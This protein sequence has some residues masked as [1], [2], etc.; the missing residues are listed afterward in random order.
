MS[1]LFCAVKASGKANENLCG[2]KGTTFFA[3]VQIKVQFF[4][5]K[6]VSCI[7][8]KTQNVISNYPE[9]CNVKL[10]K[11]HENVRAGLRM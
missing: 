8:R 7:K 1:L 2:C 3:Y 6:E 4:R 5:G 10:V 9:S 11:K